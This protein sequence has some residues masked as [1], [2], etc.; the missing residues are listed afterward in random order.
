[1]GAANGQIEAVFAQARNSHGWPMA[2]NEAQRRIIAADPRI[3]AAK[4]E[5]LKF[6]SSDTVA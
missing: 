1:M 5:L 6:L 3:T 2:S 4:E